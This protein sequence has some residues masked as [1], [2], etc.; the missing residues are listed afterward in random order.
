MEPQ[1]KVPGGSSGFDL[2]IPYIEEILKSRK[3]T[4]ETADLGPLKLNVK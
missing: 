3:F 2:N 1:I 4:T